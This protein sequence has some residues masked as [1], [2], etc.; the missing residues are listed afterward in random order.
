MQSSALPEDARTADLDHFVDSAIG[1]T[2]QSRV[3]MNRLVT[4]KGKKEE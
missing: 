4:K 2:K 3:T 1:L